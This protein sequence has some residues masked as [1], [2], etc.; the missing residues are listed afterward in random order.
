MTPQVKI[1]GNRLAIG[2]PKKSRAKTGKRVNY[3]TCRIC[4]TI[5]YSRELYYDHMRTHANDP[6][7]FTCR[8]CEFVTKRKYVYKTHLLRHS[9]ARP[10]QCQHCTYACRQASLLQS[11]IARHHPEA[12][13]IQVEF[14]AG[15]EVST[16]DQLQTKEEK[17]S[18]VCDD[19][20]TT[21]THPDIM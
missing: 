3:I 14:Y 20:I 7:V 5:F 10:F 12:D 13:K 11:H 9:G 6:N 19:E 8:H 16:P 15:H 4:E 2:K 1:V 17:M 18:G 21:L